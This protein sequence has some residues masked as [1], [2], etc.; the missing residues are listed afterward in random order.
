MNRLN[1]W[2]AMVV[3]SVSCGVARAEEWPKWLGPDGTGI[4]TEKIADHWPKDGPKKLWTQKVGLGFSSV[5]ALDGKVYMFAMQG[6]GDTLTALDAQTGK[7]LWTQSYPVTH[8]ATK[9]TDNALDR[10]T[11]LPLPEAT[12]SIDGQRIYTYGGG[13][14]LVCRDLADGKEAWRLN[15]LDATNA[16][17]LDWNEGSSPLVSGDLVYVQGGKGSAVAV[18]VNKSDGKLAWKAQAGLG[19]YAAPILADVDGTPQIIIFGGNTLFGLNPMTGKTIWTQ[20]WKTQYDV[21]AATPIFHD[22]HLFVTSSYGSGCGMFTLSP[23][24][25][26]K[27]WKNKEISS[28]FQSCILDNGRLYGNSSGRLKCLAWPSGKQIWS[29]S[30]IDLNEGGS[31]IIDASQLIA[32]SEKGQLSLVHLQASG[33][34]VVAE[35]NVF[36]YNQVWS[37]P[38]IYQ[39]KL[40]VK[41]KE[42]LVCLDIK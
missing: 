2:I 20:P 21:N 14:D 6:R 22:K 42:E 31:F 7:V 5:V 34:K 39:G 33:P 40:Y 28:K 8:K 16:Q 12:P 30:N 24:G 35:V 19:G 3:L 27:D 13:G 9:I 17:I 4:S 37:A 36:D 25:A 38:V 1:T 29:S 26:K 11:G 15:V 23:T 18:A 41:G 32:L 10:D